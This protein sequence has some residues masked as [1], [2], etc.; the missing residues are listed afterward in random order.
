MEWGSGCGGKQEGK[1]LWG[2]DSETVKMRLQDWR[3]PVAE[4]MEGGR[5]RGTGDTEPSRLMTPGF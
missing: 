3:L 2:G 1:D 4:D 5:R